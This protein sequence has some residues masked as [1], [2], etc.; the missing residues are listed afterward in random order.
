MPSVGTISGKLVLNIQEWDKGVKK[1]LATAK[2]FQRDVSAVFK[3]TRTN[4]ETFTGSMRTLKAAFVQGK[5]GAQQYTA[6]MRLLREQLAA[7]LPGMQAQIPAIMAYRADIRKLATAMKAGVITLK[8]YR[9]ALLNLKTAYV[10]ANPAPLTAAMT[11]QAA[12][13]KVLATSAV[14]VRSSL[15]AYAGPLAAIFAIFKTFK[16]QEDIERAMR[17]SLAIMKDVTGEMRRE[18]RQTA[19][20]VARNTVSSTKEAANA[21]FFLASAGLDGA[22]SL[23]AL[24][25]VAEFA[26][27]GMFD[28]SRATDLLT[29]AQMA[30]GLGSKNAEKNL[31]G[32]V[33]VSDV[34]VKANT[35][36]NA[37]VS[38]FSESLTNKAA[39]AA[40]RYGQS[41][42]EVVAI[43]IVYASQGIK[44][45]GAGSQ[46]DI[47]MKNLTIKALENADAFRRLNVDVYDP[48]TGQVRFLGDIMA[49][50]EKTM[51]GLTTRER[52]LALM[53]L[54]FTKKTISATAALVGFSDVAKESLAKLRDATGETADVAG[55]QLTEF[56]KGWENL[57]GVMTG[58]SP[59]MQAVLD[60]I[61][62][63][64][65]LFADVS[66][67]I[68]GALEGI[69]SL[70]DISEPIDEV[71]QA[72][73]EVDAAIQKVIKSREKEA[74]QRASEID[75]MIQSAGDLRTANVAEDLQETSLEMAA[76]A[77]AA[78]DSADAV[79]KFR[80]ELRFDEATADMT[81]MEKQLAKLLENLPNTTE[82]W[83]E[84][85]R[86]V[87]AVIEAQDRLDIAKA[88]KEAEDALQAVVDLQDQLRFEEATE[89]LTALEKQLAKLRENLP[90]TT[91]AWIEY[92]RAVDAVIDADIAAELK[93]TEDAAKSF[94]EQLTNQ[95]ATSEEKF[96]KLIKDLL[97]WRDIMGK[98]PGFDSGLF[99]KAVKGAKGEFLKGITQRDPSD[100]LVDTLSKGSAEAFREEIGGRQKDLGLELAQKQVDVLELVVI[101]EKRAADRVVRAINDQPAVE[102]VP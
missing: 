65:G 2:V 87:D 67:R 56:Q 12:V 25:A 80:D 40:R 95:F 49:D 18:M 21:Y 30:L 86:A 61:G 6:G 11:R 76:I 46:Y 78:E 52:V 47:V 94:G 97:Q 57:S 100:F 74:F 55:K 62:K 24:P 88:A 89:D 85:N 41:L 91:E 77:A 58:T 9:G 79:A 23:K 29:D 81:A 59:T 101:G 92:N 7:T 37:T 10:A 96:A 75:A 36:A 15:L 32:L 63:G 69:R 3:A 60:N 13:G 53:T 35:I 50:L 93:K 90:N 31:A 48:L 64:M 17:G 4:I 84:Y 28:L 82:A 33:R 54:G 42:E 19:I 1:S 38:Q 70:S 20:D 22:Q 34:L 71:T 5:I 98:L 45:A 51:E 72:A 83:I 26:Q 43:L 44:G 8:Q 102:A 66:D 73:N 27:A 16:I 39:A 68:K 14:A 99:D